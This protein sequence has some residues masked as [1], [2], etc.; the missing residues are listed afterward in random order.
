MRTEQGAKPRGNFRAFRKVAVLG[1][2]ALLALGLTRLAQGYPEVVERV[3]SRGIYP[4]WG[5]VMSTLTGLLP[6]SLSEVLLFA[7][8][9]LLVV[10]IVQAVR[11]RLSVQ[12][13][14]S[15][16]LCVPLTG[17]LL[18]SVGWALNYSRQPYSEIAGLPVQAVEVNTLERLV[19]RL[20]EQAGEL[21]AQLDPGVGAYALEVDRREVLASY[22]NEAYACAAEKYP[23]LG[24]HYGAPKFALL[25]TPLAYCNISGIFSPFTLEAH[26]NAHESD[27]LLAATAAHEGA[28]L[29]GFAREDE[30]NFIAYQVCMESPEVYVRYSGT[31]L[32][33]LYAGNALAESDPG[34][35]AAAWALYSPGVVSDLMAYNDNWK[36]FDGQAAEVHEQLNDAY[37]KANGQ[38]EGVRSYGRMV[39]LLIAQMLQEEGEEA[40]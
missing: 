3:Y 12:R 7:L 15:A 35:Y 29:R 31:L 21:R 38:A 33:L 8:P 25:S 20:A 19:L 13:L 24:G 11:R 17:Y 34:A 4:V 14:V 23:W 26:V 22:V 30:A 1:V 5:Q 6:V 40:E 27:A 9:V 28:H 32:A 39:D 36:A 37:L 2:A 18:F 10:G 16:A